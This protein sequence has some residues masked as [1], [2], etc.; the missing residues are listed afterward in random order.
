VAFFGLRTW[1]AGRLFDYEEEAIVQAGRFERGTIHA[2]AFSSEQGFMPP[3]F[4][5]RL[6]FGVRMF[7]ASGDRDP[8][9]DT[10]ESFDP[11][12]P[13][14]AYSGKAVQIG[15]TNL[16]K[17]GPIVNITLISRIRMNF[18]W[19]HFWRTSLKD[20]LYGT[21]LTLVRTGLQTSARKV[22]SQTTIEIDSR[23]TTHLS[24]WTSFIFFDAGEFLKE[25]PPGNDLRYIA[26]HVAYRF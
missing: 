1:R 24:L 21:N 17:S 12:F 22:G 10:L 19:A 6:R 7:F 18:D 8:L 9:K 16:I 14:T 5:R 11:L 15:P 26:A 23:L 25:T 2:W 3:Q 4:Q 13:G 20:G